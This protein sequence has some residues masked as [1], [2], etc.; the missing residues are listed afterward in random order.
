MASLGRH[1][2]FGNT[3]FQYLFLKAF[4]HEYGFGCEV[5]NWPGQR[6]FGHADLPM[7]RHHEVVLRDN[8]SLVSESASNIASPLD[9]ELNR[10]AT[11]M[12]CGRQVYLL[13]QL[14]IANDASELPFQHADLE[15]LFIV[16][17][18]H[19]A[20]YREYLR[21]LLRPVPRIA[22]GL[23]R[24]VEKIR[25]L[26]KT[27]IG[28]HMR[29]GD[30]DQC[31]SAQGFEFV[32]PLEWYHRWLDEVWRRVEDPV[33]LVCSD[34]PEEAERF[35]RYKP[36]A[37]NSLDA[38]T[39]EDLVAD[40]EVPWQ[41]EAEYLRDWWLLTQCDRLAISNSTFSFSA[42]MMNERCQEFLRPDPAR[43]SL[44]P[45]DPWNAEPLLMLKHHATAP[46]EFLYRLRL[47]RAGRGN[48]AIAPG[49][50]MALRYYRWM[51]QNRA[52]AARY[53]HGKRG[54]IRELLTPAFYL[55]A[56]R[57]YDSMSRRGHPPSRPR[58]ARTAP[59]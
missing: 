56:R 49:I 51:L 22:D 50:K 3:I 44:V 30:F 35:A 58:P 55:S 8:M 27:I 47:A 31:F 13:N 24:S 4:A 42:A 59:T 26:G 15:G 52:S 45:F 20:P 54:L 18:D 14:K 41:R 6:F 12:E 17:T 29:R 5:P 25:S 9:G 11:L 28:V 38:V 57:H 36:V 7:T 32:A 40:L 16:R 1:G 2:R 43:S 34:N 23:R 19:L 33:L 21:D 48:A 53:F 37:A 39:F 10:A 46:G